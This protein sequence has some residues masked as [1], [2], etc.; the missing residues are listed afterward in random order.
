MILL[1]DTQALIWS[2]ESG[3]FLSATARQAIETAEEVY[4]SPINFYEIAI[5]L[6]LGRNA[7]VTRP[8][9]TLISTAQEN[10]FT[11]LPLLPKHIEAYAKLPFFDH[12]RDPFDRLILATAMAEEL[13]VV[14]SDH[15]FPLYQEVVNVLW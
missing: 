13:T 15:N 10:G 3:R 8:I 4:I 9:S 6:T 12:H 5:K 11:W 1:L 14:S 7:G 2:L